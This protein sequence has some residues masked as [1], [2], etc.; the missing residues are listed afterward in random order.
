MDS[1]FIEKSPQIIE[2]VQRAYKLSQEGSFEEC[3]SLL[4]KLYESKRVYIQQV[5]A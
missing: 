4:M 1:Y 3:L 2:E 5:N